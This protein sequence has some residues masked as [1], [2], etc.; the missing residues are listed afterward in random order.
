MNFI[1]SD[2]LDAKPTRPSRRSNK[3]RPEMDAAK[4]KFADDR[5]NS[6]TWFDTQNPEDWGF[7]FDADRKWIWADPNLTPDDKDKIFDRMW[8]AMEAHNRKATVEGG[9][10][11][12]QT[13]YGTELSEQEAAEYRKKAAGPKSWHETLT[14][15]E[16]N[17]ILPY[18]EFERHPDWEARA[19]TR[20]HN[21]INMHNERAAEQGWPIYDV[22]TG[23]QLPEDQAATYRTSTNL[24]RS[25]W[26]IVALVMVQPIAVFIIFYITE[27]MHTDA[28]TTRG[29]CLFT[30]FFAAF[31]YA[32]TI[33]LFGRTFVESLKG[34]ILGLQML[35]WFSLLSFALTIAGGMIIGWLHLFSP[36]F[37]VYYGVLGVIAF[38]F[39]VVTSAAKYKIAMRLWDPL[40]GAMHP[41]KKGFLTFIGMVIAAIFLHGLSNR[42]GRSR[43]D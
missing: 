33:F 12:N 23:K 11:Y 16:F 20:A 34:S 9:P 14:R 6:R 13:N 27:M 15:E 38:F 26:R 42:I 1:P 2:L 18:D 24:K 5:G 41:M 40:S 39:F 10:I 7:V 32:M 37:E 29:L 19:A 43:N 30:A 22:E 3:R 36:P 31:A 35:N 21:A 17:A 28:S 8:S 25:F 4:G